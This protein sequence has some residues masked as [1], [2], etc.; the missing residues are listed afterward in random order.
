[1]EN[2]ILKHYIVKI[3]LL[4]D[5]EEISISTIRAHLEDKLKSIEGIYYHKIKVIK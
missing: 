2:E 5:V 1:M 3:E 4:V